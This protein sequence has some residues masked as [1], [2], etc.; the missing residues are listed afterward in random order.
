M[1][2][3]EWYTMQLV[4]EPWMEPACWWGRAAA[5]LVAPQPSSFP[6]L[7]K[8]KE[9]IIIIIII[10]KRRWNVLCA[11]GWL[12]DSL[13]ARFSPLGFRHWLPPKAVG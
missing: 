6:N 10:T 5:L 2:S 13:Y 8:K 7:L 9:I 3:Y 4:S 11:F 1:G 12:F